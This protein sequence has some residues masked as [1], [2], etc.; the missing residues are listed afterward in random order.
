MLHRVITKL[1]P[2]AGENACV[3]A[4]VLRFALKVCSYLKRDNEEVELAEQKAVTPTLV[5]RVF[6]KKVLFLKLNNFFISEP[7]LMKF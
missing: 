7:I 5:Y 3:N 2:H 6:H 1:R 4:S